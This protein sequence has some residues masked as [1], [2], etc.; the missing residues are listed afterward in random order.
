MTW[1]NA[2]FDTFNNE[3]LNIL[4]SER[5]ISKI[6]KNN[7]LE[8]LIFSIKSNITD[9]IYNSILKSIKKNN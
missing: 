6:N 7:L 4:F 3:N 1:E 5:G 9:S 2:E 8:Q